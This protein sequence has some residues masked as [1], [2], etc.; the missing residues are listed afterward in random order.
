MFRVATR[1]KKQKPG[2]DSICIGMIVSIKSPEYEIL[3]FDST[4]NLQFLAYRTKNICWGFLLASGTFCLFFGFF[5]IFLFKNVHLH[6]LSNPS[7]GLLRNS[8][9]FFLS[10]HKFSNVE[11]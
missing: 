7:F 6:P 3:Y 1:R 9:P 10:W 5:S 11:V 2:D 8:S 4:Y